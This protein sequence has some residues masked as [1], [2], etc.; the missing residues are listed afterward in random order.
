MSANTQER[1]A[2]FRRIE[3]AGWER[4]AGGYDTYFSDVAAQM[5]DPILDAAVP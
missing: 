1:L 5:I 4:L 3:H 2:N